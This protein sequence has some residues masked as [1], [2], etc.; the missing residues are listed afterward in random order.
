MPEGYASNLGKRA[1]VLEGKLVGM[2]SHDCHVFMETLVPIA[3]RGLPE[4]IWKPI[5]EI[6]LFFKELCSNTL[7]EDTLLLMNQNIRVTSCKLEKFL[8][9]GFFDVMEHLPVHLV[10][11]ALLGG[12]VQYRWMYPWE[13]KIGKC[14]RF[15][16][17]KNRIEGSICEAYLANSKR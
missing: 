12:P 1:D 9:C 2:K 7:R 4:R 10:Q 3:F 6:S 8:P 15:V 11:E 14:K 13:R 5:T 17:Q 16:K